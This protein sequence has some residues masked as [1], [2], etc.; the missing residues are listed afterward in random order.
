MGGVDRVIIGLEAPDGFHI[1][2]RNENEPRRMLFRKIG[3]RGI[4]IA[5]C[6]GI[7]FPWVNMRGNNGKYLIIAFRKA[8]AQAEIKLL[9]KIGIATVSRMRGDI[10]L[11]LIPKHATVS[12]AEGWIYFEIVITA[13]LIIVSRA[14]GIIIFVRGIEVN[15]FKMHCHGLIFKGICLGD[16]ALYVGAAAAG[17]D[18]AHGDLP[19]SFKEITVKLSCK[20]G[21]AGR[22]CAVKEE[23][24][25]IGA[26]VSFCDTADCAVRFY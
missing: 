2:K 17:V 1:A 13:D 4:K 19:A 7:E 26:A 21:G 11:A 16:P 18:E 8:R 25:G 3:Y 15:R 23:S 9:E 12:D 10:A 20:G 5:S 24:C 22:W 14:S 6:T